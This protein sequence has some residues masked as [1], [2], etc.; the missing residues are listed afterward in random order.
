MPVDYD[1]FRY[2]FRYSENLTFRCACQFLLFC[3]DLLPYY[4]L[5]PF[6]G[7]TCLGL[8]CSTFFQVLMLIYLLCRSP[9]SF[10]HCSLDELAVEHRVADNCNRSFRDTF[11]FF[12]VLFFGSSPRRAVPQ[13][14]EVFL[15]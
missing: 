13:K 7:L 8:L 6:I 2:L 5:I 9:H 15:P 11:F 4:G 3:T 1:C 10:P 14:V 12:V